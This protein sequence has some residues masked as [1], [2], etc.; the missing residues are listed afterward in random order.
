MR[1]GGPAETRLALCESCAEGAGDTSRSVGRGG[2][3]GYMEKP[4]ARRPTTE[5]TLVD[6]EGAFREERYWMV[7]MGLVAYIR[8]GEASRHSE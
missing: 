6:D 1:D 4:N 2:A 5:W 3:R 8:L 7:A